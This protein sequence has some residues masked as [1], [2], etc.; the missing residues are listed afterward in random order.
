M[1]LFSKSLITI[2]TGLPLLLNNLSLLSN[3]LIQSKFINF[4]V[5]LINQIM[6]LTIKGLNTSTVKTKIIRN[7]IFAFRPVSN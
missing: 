3:K 5:S 1:I 6:N 2:N 7:Q 4:L